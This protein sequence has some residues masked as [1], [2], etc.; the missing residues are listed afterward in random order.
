MFFNYLMSFGVV[1]LFQW[2]S[3]GSHA[4]SVVSWMISGVHGCSRV[5]NGVHSFHFSSVF[6]V[7]L[8]VVFQVC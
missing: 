2:G 3:N 8:A 1:S 6:D 5:F 7:F 4:I